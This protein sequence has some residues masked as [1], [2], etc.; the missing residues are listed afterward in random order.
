LK[1]RI[2]VSRHSN[3]EVD[4]DTRKYAPSSLFSLLSIRIPYVPLKF[5]SDDPKMAEFVSQATFLKSDF[6]PCVTIEYPLEQDD[7]TASETD[8][9]IWTRFES[10]LEHVIGCIPGL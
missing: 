2:I 3:F 8:H 10:I 9:W 6:G 1:F 7:L 4:F 5:K